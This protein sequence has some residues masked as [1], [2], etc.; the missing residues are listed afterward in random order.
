METNNM[1]TTATNLKR[2]S[3]IK[4]DCEVGYYFIAQDAQG[5]EVIVPTEHP[6]QHYEIVNPVIPCPDPYFAAMGAR[7]SGGFANEQVGKGTN[8]R[9]TAI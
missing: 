9:Y 1:E 7:Y 6:L 3:G 5:N 2:L 8:Y 4:Q